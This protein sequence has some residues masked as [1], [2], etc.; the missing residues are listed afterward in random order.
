M[1]TNPLG[2]Q[3]AEAQPHRATGATVTH[4]TPRQARLIAALLANPD[5]QSAARAA[6]V[7]CST[8]HRWLKLPAFQE[9]VGKQRDAFMRES[10]ASVK[11][12]SARAVRGLAALLDTADDRLRRLV[13]NDLLQH[14]LRVHELQ[15]LERRM[16]LLEARMEDQPKGARK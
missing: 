11:N 10:L 3:R 14:N 2:N 9:E 7:G 4:V 1:Q 16:D 6:G 5:V 13:C 8:A 12:H 15:Q